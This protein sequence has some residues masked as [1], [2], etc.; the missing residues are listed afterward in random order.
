MIIDDGNHVVIA[1]FLLPS[2]AVPRLSSVPEPSAISTSRVGP[3]RTWDALWHIHRRKSRPIVT[4]DEPTRSPCPSFWRA[5]C[6]K[7]KQ[8]WHAFEA[9]KSQPPVDWVLGVGVLLC[10]VFWVL[11]VFE[12]FVGFVCFVN[13]FLVFGVVLVY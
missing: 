3:A 12:F 2:S 10:C 4:I 9:R 13:F 7:T 8:V 5:G 6:K 1:V 11:S